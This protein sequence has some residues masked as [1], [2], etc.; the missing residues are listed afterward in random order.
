MDNEPIG[1]RAV[2]KLPPKDKDLFTFAMGVHDGFLGNADL[3]NPNPLLSVFKADVIAFQDAATKALLRTKGTVTLRRAKRKKVV[4]DLRHLKNYVQSVVETQTDPVVAAAI[5]EG[6]LMSVRKT[7]KR[8]RP[9][10]QARNT[11]V[12]GEVAVDAAQV[13]KVAVYYWEFSL[14]QTDWSTF[15]ET[16]QANTVISGLTPGRIYY[17]R[18]RALTRKER[19][20]YSQVV[21]LMVT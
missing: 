8:S 9:E 5:I 18:F 20:G 7:G 19:R 3:P 13:A 14:N 15:P 4:A 2:L 6:V 12:S 10:L 1:P 21:R 17:F 11:A 16:L